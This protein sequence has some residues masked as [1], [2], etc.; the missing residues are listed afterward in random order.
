MSLL[1]QII[2]VIKLLVSLLR[3]SNLQPNTI[4]S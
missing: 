4:T 3:A 1:I 2:D